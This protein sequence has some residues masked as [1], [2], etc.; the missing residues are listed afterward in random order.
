MLYKDYTGAC[1]GLIKTGYHF[2]KSMTED[3]EYKLRMTEKQKN[4]SPGA[5]GKA[6]KDSIK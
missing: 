4:N 2:C 5:C 3:E 1:D 6:C